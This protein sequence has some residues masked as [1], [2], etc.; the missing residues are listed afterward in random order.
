MA[1]YEKLLIRLGTCVADLT[2]AMKDIIATNEVME[3]ENRQLLDR[4]MS[5]EGQNFKLRKTIWRLKSDFG[6]T[7]EG[8]EIHT[9][10]KKDQFHRS[11]YPSI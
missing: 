7:C 1:N 11:R 8:V 4:L 2:Y 5:L 3:E 6:C 10:E 9:C